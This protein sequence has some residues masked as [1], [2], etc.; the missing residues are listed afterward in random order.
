MLF[1]AFIP[2]LVYVF[3]RNF[4]SHLLALL[5]LERNLD[6]NRLLFSQIRGMRSC[7]HC[8]TFL[9]DTG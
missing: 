3:A 2:A 6:S 1:R 5:L 7:Q 9:Q 8:F 4:V